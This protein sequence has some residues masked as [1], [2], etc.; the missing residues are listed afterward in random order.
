MM[1]FRDHLGEF[2]TP[3]AQA[4]IAISHP[5]PDIDDDDDSGGG[6]GDGDGDGGGGGGGGYFNIQLHDS[7]DEE[8]PLD[9]QVYEVTTR[10]T[11]GRGVLNDN[12][13]RMYEPGRGSVGTHDHDN[14]SVYSS[15]WGYNQSRDNDSSGG[16]INHPASSASYGSSYGY[17]MGVDQQPYGGHY[18]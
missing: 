6:D 16:M 9:P 8:T 15:G 17:W 13:Q 1:S 7:T 2:G 4:G 18:G 11:S 14:E 3:A 5:E 12:S 10:N